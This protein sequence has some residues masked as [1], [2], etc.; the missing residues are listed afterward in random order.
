MVQAPIARIGN[1]LARH[2]VPQRRSPHWIDD[3]DARQIA[4]V[5]EAILALRVR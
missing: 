4:R 5:N 2:G 1:V 3:A